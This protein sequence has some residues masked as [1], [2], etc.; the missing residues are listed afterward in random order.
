MAP[1]SQLLKQ[2]IGGIEWWV[3]NVV[4]KGTDYQELLQLDCNIV[5]GVLLTD[6]LTG[7]KMT[8]DTMTAHFSG[9]DDDL[10]TRFFRI[11]Q[12]YVNLISSLDPTMVQYAMEL[13]DRRNDYDR[14]I[15]EEGFE[16]RAFMWLRY[17]HDVRRIRAMRLYRKQNGRYLEYT[18]MTS[19]KKERKTIMLKNA[20]IFMTRNEAF[21]WW[22]EGFHD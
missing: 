3:Q 9:M 13:A 10:R 7:M 12:L 6:T 19:E 1:T 18:D 5:D 8:P 17:G 11:A 15:I 4:A 16:S 20:H 22:K 21:M 14:M 2:H